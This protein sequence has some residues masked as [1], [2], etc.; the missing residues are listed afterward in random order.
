MA[1]GV[2]ESFWTVERESEKSEV[3]D[4]TRIRRQA[5]SNKGPKGNDYMITRRR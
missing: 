4:S 5:D 1:G 3:S 2:P